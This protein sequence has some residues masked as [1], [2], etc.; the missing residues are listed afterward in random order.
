M[1]AP[2]GGRHERRIAVNGDAVRRYKDLAGRNTEAMHRLREH[3]RVV[4]EQLRRRLRDAELA[5]FQSV[6]RERM[7]NVTIRMHWESVVEALWAERWL[8]IGQQP[9][10]VPPPPGMTANEADADVER[11]Y[12]ALRDALAKAGMLSRRHRQD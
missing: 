12:E 8:P 2:Q 1:T 10:A 3:D 4:C 11:A 6:A 9:Q 7:S 5:L